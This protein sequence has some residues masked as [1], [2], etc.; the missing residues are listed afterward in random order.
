MAAGAVPII[1]DCDPGHDDAIAILL[2]LASPAVD[3]RAVTTT[4]GNCSRGGRDPQRPASARPSPATRRPGRRRRGRPARRGRELG[5]YVHGASGLDGP[6]LPRAGVRG[7]STQ[8]AVE[9]MAAA[10]DAAPTSR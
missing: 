4:F 2:A 1:L 6:Q 9:L 5:N 8:H 7:R 10:A 3:L